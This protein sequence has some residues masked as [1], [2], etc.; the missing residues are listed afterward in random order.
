M[1]GL[2]IQLYDIVMLA[3]LVLTTLFGLWKG[4]AW[5]LASLGSLVLSS[6]VAMQFSGPLAPYISDKEPWNRFIAMLILYL[7]TSLAVWLVFRLV[8]GAIDRVRLKEFDRQLG[9]LFGLAKGCLLCLVITFFGV[10]L[11]E[12][13]RQAVLKSESGKYIALAIH[14]AG[15]VMP[16]EVRKYLDKLDQKLDH[17][18]ASPATPSPQRTDPSPLGARLTDALAAPLTGAPPAPLTGAPPDPV[19]DRPLGDKLKAE[20]RDHFQNKFDQQVDEG[21]NRLDQG[22]D[23]IRKGIETR[24]NEGLN[25]IQGE[26]E[27][28][29]DQGLET[30][31]FRRWLVE[32]AGNSNLVA[33]PGYRVGQ[34]DVLKIRQTDPAGGAGGA[35]E[36]LYRVGADGS[37]DLGPVGRV[38]VAGQ[39]L[40][41]VRRQIEGRLARTSPG[42]GVS[43]DVA[44]AEREVFYVIAGSAG[45]GGNVWR[46][47]AS[48]NDTIEAALAGAGSSP[49]A[50][51]KIWLVRPAPE[52]G[53]PEQVLPVQWDAASRRATPNYRI[54]PG[55]AVF[56]G[57]RTSPWTH[58]LDGWVTAWRQWL[59]R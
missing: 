58:D 8:A 2:P 52:G 6:V 59:R 19:D 21:V 46:V 20:I 12:T 18:D 36:G 48:G 55:D 3:V 42:S 9:A 34:D 23:S 38:Q 5:Q 7:V 10:T 49:G 54:S 17:D 16:E 28:R 51:E 32:P 14:K 4:M 30:L 27:T 22:L 40:A 57:Q 35:V 11:S 37:V 41:D 50:V 53:G 47:R 13:V 56:V 33:L 24:V 1:D 45:Q 25:T 44:A 29:L 39:R 15:P 26:F 31:D 43:V